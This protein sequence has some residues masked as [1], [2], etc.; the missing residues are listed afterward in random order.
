MCI[1]FSVQMK[2]EN[3][4]KSL[5]V[6]LV[7]SSVDWEDLLKHPCYARRSLQSGELAVNLRLMLSET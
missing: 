6:L 4:I 5:Q 2:W 3:L 1:F 7:K